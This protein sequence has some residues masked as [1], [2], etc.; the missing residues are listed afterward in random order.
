MGERRSVQLLTVSPPQRQVLV[1]LPLEPFVV[2]SLQEVNHLM[3][4][5]VLKAFTWFLGQFC[6]QANRLGGRI[7][8]PPLG[9][10][11]LYEEPFHPHR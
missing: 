10:H 1:H 7:A 9:L 2:M 6:I 8:A 3:H 4:N 11:P 5:D